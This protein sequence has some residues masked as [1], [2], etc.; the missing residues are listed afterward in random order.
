MASN[1]IR[2]M[3]KEKS[4]IKNNLQVFDRLLHY[5]YSLYFKRLSRV[6]NK[7]PHNSSGT[8]VKNRQRILSVVLKSFANDWKRQMSFAREA[9]SCVARFGWKKSPAR[10]TDRLNVA[11]ER[12]MRAPTRDSRKDRIQ[13][14]RRSCCETTG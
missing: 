11:R 13:Q 5:Y 4:G 1:S 10:I 2:Y 7:H 3:G 14:E 6:P 9:H 8:D 12:W